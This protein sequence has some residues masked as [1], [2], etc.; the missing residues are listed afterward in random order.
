MKVRKTVFGARM[1]GPKPQTNVKHTSNLPRKK[2]TGSDVEPPNQALGPKR[3]L[4]SSPVKKGDKIVPNDRKTQLHNRLTKLKKEQRYL[5]FEVDYRPATPDQLKKDVK[6]DTCIYWK[7]GAACHLVLGY[8]HADMWCNKWEQSELLQKALASKILS[9]VKELK[10]KTTPKGKIVQP[11]SIHSHRDD[12]PT[13]LNKEGDGGGDGGTDGGGTVFTS[14]NS[15]IFSPTHGGNGQKKKKKSGIEKL[16]A[17]ITD[18]SPEKKM[19]KA[20]P[21]TLTGLVDAVRMD[22]QKD[23]ERRKIKRQTPYNSKPIE[24]DPPQSIEGKTSKPSPI[25]NQLSSGF[26]ANVSQVDALHRAGDKDIIEPDED[27]NI[28]EEPENIKMKRIKR[29]LE[30]KKTGKYDIGEALIKSIYGEDFD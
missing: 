22:L 5:K 7:D 1:E 12:H 20:T 25:E 9:P 23:D 13:H 24:D 26:G 18:N 27:E 6:C 17:F 30:L 19:V 14:T 10:E 15:G 4:V 2:G 16:G 8:I 11:P 29:A 21:E 3:E 28:P